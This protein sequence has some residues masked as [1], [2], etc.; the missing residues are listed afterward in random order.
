MTTPYGAWPSPVDAGQVAAA[1]VDLGHLELADGTAYWLERR[2]SEEGRGVVVRQPGGGDREA[3]TPADHDVRTLVHEYGGGDF[4][5]DDGALYYARFENQRLYRVDL[6]ADDPVATVEPVT[7][8]PETDRGLR[9]AD[10]ELAESRLYAV[11]ERHEGP[12]ADEE[13]VNELVRVPLDGS[14]DGESESE[15]EG[16]AAVVAEGHDFYSFPR[17][18]PSGDRLAWT[19]WD[20][21]QMPW[22]GTTLH[23]A[24][25]GVDGS[26]TDERSVMGGPDE[27]V[28]GPSWGP[29]GEL[30]A[31]TDRTGW[32]NL[33]RVDPTGGEPENLHPADEEFGTPQWVFGLS[34]YAPLS[35][36]RIAAVHG[37]GDDW[38]LGVLDP[39]TGD[40][41]DFATGYTAFPHT[42]LDADDD[43]LTV[44]ASPTEPESVVRIDATAATG[45]DSPAADATVLRRSLS[46]DLARR[47][48]SEPESVTFETTGGDLAHARYYPPHNPDVAAPDDERPPLLATV[49]GGP[50]SQSLPTFDPEVQYFTSR[51]VGVVDV[52]Y[53]GS[54]G[55]GR[56]Y[57]EQL[58][59]A[60]GVVDTADCVAAATR[61]AGDR[62]DPERLAIRGGS[63]GGY[64]ALCALAFHDTFD[65]G[66]SYYGVADLRALAEHT[67][68]FESRYLDSLVG[69]LP[70]AADVYDE[71]S[72]V[73][74]ADGIAA[75]LLLLQGS[76]DA[77]VPPAQA[78]VMVDALAANGV[79]HAHVEFEDERHG[80][81]RE[82]SRRRALELE[83]AF[84][85]QVFGFTPDDDL[86]TVDLAVE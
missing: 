70:D 14:G 47:Y 79:P 78:E 3:V 13:P 34:T 57:R 56:A 7:P 31:V 5:V 22:D 12:D 23:V 84:L 27:S 45:G 44:A 60:W 9:Y 8:A 41:T 32:W 64:A 20:H 65:A 59:G 48:V 42:R 18:S 38:A 67:H 49:H 36:G 58:R 6:T 51:G 30:Y 11:R 16:E 28:F 19:T 69:P 37:A 85:G 68:K 74:H 81:R 15:G 35:D 1:G 75:P 21:P 43:L 10:L 86:P 39:E 50:T 61:L 54:T 83:F 25:V 17:L 63:A 46:V 26:L 4:A 29:D 71:R 24:D 66:V 52:N 33:Y 55:Y 72:P 80:F 2:P 40:L 82:D 76:E 73:E 77:V 53:R 62:V